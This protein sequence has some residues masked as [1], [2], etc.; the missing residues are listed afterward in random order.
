[1]H[2]FGIAKAMLKQAIEKAGSNAKKITR[3]KIKAGHLEMLSQESLQI[4]FDDIAKNSIAEGCRIE[5]EEFP[6]KGMSVES[7]EVES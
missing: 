6:G 7:M 4:A 5:Y 2:E 1:M 3:I